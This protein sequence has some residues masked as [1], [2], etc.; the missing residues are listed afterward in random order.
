LTAARS[1]R[2]RSGRVRCR[3][4]L[5]VVLVRRARGRPRPPARARA[6][7]RSGRARRPNFRKSRNLLRR[8]ERGSGLFFRMECARGDGVYQ[9][10]L[11]VYPGIPVR[12]PASG[13]RRA[14][15]TAVRNPACV[16]GVFRPTLKA[17]S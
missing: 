4:R 17:L 5:V 16:I 9:V 13:V 6:R 11:G 10:Y 1:L 15:A 2:R 7:A 12:R 8:R 3:K 14:V